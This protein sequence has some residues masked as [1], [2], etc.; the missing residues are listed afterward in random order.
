VGGDGGKKANL[1]ASWE[2]MQ[3]IRPPR[4]WI[5]RSQTHWRRSNLDSMCTH[6]QREKKNVFFVGFLWVRDGMGEKEESREAEG[7]NGGEPVSQ[8]G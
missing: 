1:A 3:P 7:G 5:K 8:K 4:R 6:T 2:T